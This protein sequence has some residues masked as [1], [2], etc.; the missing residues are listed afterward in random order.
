MLDLPDLPVSVTLG[1]Q[2]A[3]IAVAALIAFVV[4]RT[5]V[6]VSVRHLLE[7]R[8]EEAGTGS[9]L[10]AAELERRVNTIGRLVVRIA[11]AIITIIAV[12]MALELF[13]VDI[14][15]AVAGLGVVGIAVGFGAQTLVRDWLSG[16]FIVLEN[17]YSQGDVIRIAG[18]D[19]VVEDFSLRRTTLRDLDGTVHTVPNGQIIVASNMTRLWARVNLDV[20]VAYDTD[21]DAASDI[22]DRVGSDL[23]ADPEWGPRLLEPPKVVRVEALSDSSVSLKVLG[24][25]RA[26]E[27]WAVGGELRKRI[28]AAFT[29]AGIRV[30][31]P[32][33]V[34]VNQ[35]SA[36]GDAGATTGD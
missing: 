25:V 9:V 30:P 21:L 16:I 29:R 28:L 32:H 10:P 7:R 24:Q 19:G 8:G 34:M 27:Q 20:Q 17:Q 5:V 36:D 6:G 23:Q 26:A 14:G 22:V 35:P 3:L 12:L 31:Y 33:R 13:G 18:V 1:L 11:G 15:P 2:L 4:L